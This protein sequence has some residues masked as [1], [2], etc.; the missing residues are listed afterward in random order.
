METAAKPCGSREAVLLP[1]KPL[2]PLPLVPAALLMFDDE[3]AMTGDGLCDASL[4]SAVSAA[5]V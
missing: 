2:E 1:A 3:M 4:P 5:D